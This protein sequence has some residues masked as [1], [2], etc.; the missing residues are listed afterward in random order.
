MASDALLEHPI[1]HVLR[2]N[3]NAVASSP[4]IKLHRKML[5]QRT[6]FPH[7]DPPR[8]PRKPT[9]LDSSR[10]GHRRPNAS[11]HRVES[12]YSD[13]SDEFPSNSPRLETLRQ[14]PSVLSLVSVMDS[15]GFIPSDVFS[16]SPA[17]PC[18]APRGRL[19]R[20]HPFSR[21][22]PE[23]SL[24]TPSRTRGAYAKRNPFN[25]R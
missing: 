3:P 6:E 23:L 9:Q 18:P 25:L 22:T 17:T 4:S 16:N 8:S 1:D 12:V 15:H 24:R 10:P 20:P 5:L 14:D 13:S 7:G 21:S 2:Q 19:Q 11:L